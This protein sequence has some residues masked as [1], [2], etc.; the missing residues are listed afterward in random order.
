MADVTNSR[1][2]HEVYRQFPLHAIHFPEQILTSHHHQPTDNEPASGISYFT[3]AQVPPAGSAVNPQPSSKPIP[4]LFTPLQIRSMTLQNRIMLSPLCQYSAQDGHLTPWHITHLGGIIQRGPGLTCVEAT[5][6]TARGRITPEDSGLWKDSQMGPLKQIV[7]FAHS[8]NQKIMIQLGHAGR[9]ASTVAPWLSGGSIAYEEA[10]GWPE[11]V[12][13]PSAEAYSERLCKPK[14]M[15]LQ[16][17]ED[18]KG[19]WGEAIRRSVE[20]GFDCIEIHNAHGYLLHSF[21]SPASNHRTDRYGGSF[22][23]RTRL[24]L[25]IVDLAREIIPKDMP[26]FLRISATDW[27][28]GEK[29]MESWRIEDTIKFAAIIAE[30]GV[31]LLDVSSGGNHPKQKI[32]AGPVGKAY[33]AVS[34]LFLNPYSPFSY[35]IP[36]PIEPVIYVV[37]T[38]L[39]SPPLFPPNQPFA[40]AIKKSLPLTSPLLIGTVGSITNGPQ[41]NALLE[42]SSDPGSDGSK[43]DSTTESKTKTGTEA[44]TEKKETEKNEPEPEEPPLDLAIVGRYFQKDPGLVWTFA[45]QLGTEI[46]VANQIAWGFKG[47]GV[48]SASR[49][50]KM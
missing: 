33:Q 41:A 30:K 9:K 7:E 48:V 35:L 47:R 44:E 22:E 46:T 26:L 50:A 27:L 29:D 17:I 6:V 24:S 45:E 21:C 5:A 3:P 34:F 13:G 49:K 16:D 36:L 38:S 4:K 18:V 23:N 43:S 37:I 39:T 11:E 14:E 25:E 32:N 28:E 12:Y 20:C 31:D 2:G 15:S 40:Q 8:Q 19:A 1:T 10:N 42:G